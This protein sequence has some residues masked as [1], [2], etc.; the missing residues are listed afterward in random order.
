M[1]VVVVGGTGHIGGYLVP[2]LVD[3]G[4]EVIVLSRGQRSPYREHPA[5]SSVTR[6]DVDRAAEDRAGIFGARVAALEPDAVIDLIC[7]DRGSAEQLVAALL[8]RRPLLV[9]CGSVWVHGPATAVPVREDEA[10][11]TFGDYGIGKVAIEG[12]LLGQSA[13]GIPSV[14]LHPGHISGPGWRVINPAGNLDLGVWE[15]LATGCEVVLP[16]LGLETL[17]HVH[18]DDVALAFEL[19][20][21][22]PEA[23]GEA[24]HVVSERALTLRGYAEAVASWFGQAAN[25]RF[26]DLDDFR[27]A[28]GDENAEIT[29]DHVSRSP[30]MSGQKS[31]DR[32]GYTPQHSSLDAVR[33]A[34]A[35][36]QR[37][38][39][40]ELG[41]HPL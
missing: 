34:V 4:D 41:G 8:P 6:V 24:L 26:V 13:D 31:H 30:S 2:R 12:F 32:L 38:G 22:R 28:V 23:V 18:A 35:W 7:F 15:R 14:V 33:E 36:L 40:L 25:L 21:A 37:D 16:N 11:D 20:L 39:Q 10:R 5:W 1:R 29:L 27:C 9:S 3:R 19:A 17:H